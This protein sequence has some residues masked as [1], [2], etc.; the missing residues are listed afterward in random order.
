MARK[1]EG[2]FESMCEKLAVKYGTNPLTLWAAGKRK[3]DADA[4]DK[5]K[6]GGF[7]EKPKK[8]S[9]KEKKA[10]LRA[11]YKKHGAPLPL[12][13]LTASASASAPLEL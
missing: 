3:S 2:W 6:R 9:R 5:S 10:L 1:E 4:D 11:F 13:L 7:G 12:S 8:F